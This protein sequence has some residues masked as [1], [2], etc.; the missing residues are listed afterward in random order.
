MNE[1]IC[2]IQKL[3]DWIDNHAAEN[4]PLTEIAKQAGYSPWYCSEQFHRLTG[5]TLRDY[6]AKRRL[7]MAALALRD[8]EL[9]I[10]EIALKYGFSSQQALTRA[11]T[12]AYGCAPS[13]YRKNP[14]PIPLTMKKTVVTPSNTI[15]GDS[16]MSNL[17]IPSYRIE[18]IPAH[19]FLGVY[20]HSKTKDGPI[21]PG[22][23][24]DLLCGI[25]QSM[26]DCHP[27]V[28]RHTAGWKLVNGERK[29]FYGLGVETDYDG[30]VP[31]GFTLTDV[32]PESYYLVFCHPHF[33]YLT[34]NGDV[35]KRVENL[36]WNFDPAVLG[37]EWRE[38]ECQDYQRHYPEVLGYQVL[39]PVKK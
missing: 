7:S 2:A 27:I 8:T 3:L 10:V 35:M 4:P 39:R 36:A 9:P 5:M 19:R 28:T 15:K 32:I 34:E 30:S 16:L 37:Y 11:F 33:D 21:W 29:Y 24:C 1:R 25:V 17:V 23:D 6:M 38:N 18:H 13:A 20:G 22:H 31:E 14:L 26:P 12:A